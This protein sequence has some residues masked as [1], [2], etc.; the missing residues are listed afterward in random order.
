[1][2]VD[3]LQAHKASATLSF[4]NAACS[5]FRGEVPAEHSQSCTLRQTSKLTTLWL[6][7][8]SPP[9]TVGNGERAGRL[10][11]APSCL[12]A[13]GG[14][15]SKY[16]LSRQ[17]RWQTCDSAQCN[18][19]FLVSLCSRVIR[20]WGASAHNISLTNPLR[21]D[22]CYE[23]QCL[24]TPAFGVE[25]QWRRLRLQ[26][27]AWLLSASARARRAKRRLL[28]PSMLVRRIKRRPSV[29]RFSG[30]LFRNII[31]VSSGRR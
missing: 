23:R 16:I 15:A 17:L 28:S 2:N 22:D 14:S 8:S 10:Q 20:R 29:I 3:A 1:M 7:I 13:R 9:V 30:L 18:L 21:R 25:K 19:I 26:L 24:F 31:W 4:R 12:A 5:P 11:C 6:L 27:L